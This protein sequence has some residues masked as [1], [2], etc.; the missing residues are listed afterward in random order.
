M[1]QATLIPQ[2]FYANICA[3]SEPDEKFLCIF[4]SF[5][6]STISSY[7]IIFLQQEPSI[8]TKYKKNHQIMRKGL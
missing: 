3:C 5:T 4:H 6:L 8:R 7:L 1:K 2:I